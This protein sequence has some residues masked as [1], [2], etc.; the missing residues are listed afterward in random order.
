MKTR[1]LM[2]AIVIALAVGCSTREQKHECQIICN[3]AGFKYS[4]SGTFLGHTDCFCVFDLPI[5]EDTK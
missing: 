2:V 1:M 4:S 5:K 3:E